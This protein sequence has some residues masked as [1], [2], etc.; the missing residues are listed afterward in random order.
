MSIP[1]SY[2]DLRLIWWLLLGLLLIGFAVTDGFDF[3]TAILLPFVARNDVERRV[4]IGT[5]DRPAE[6]SQVWFVLGGGAMVAAWPQV[7]AIA[8]SGFHA[9]LFLVLTALI[10]RPVGFKFRNKVGNPLW[11]ACWDHVLFLAGLAAALVFG[12]AT[13]NVLAGVP[14][15]LDGTMRASH[16]DGLIGLLHPFA[17]LCGMLSVAM[18]VM[19]GAAWLVA[20]TG[21]RVADRA[22][23]WGQAAAIVTLVVLA[24]GW[25]WT[26][27]LPGLRIVGGADPNGASNPLAKVVVVEIGAWLANYADHPWFAIA[28]AAG[29]IGTAIAFLCLNLRLERLA[30]VASGTGVA[31]VVATAG[32]GMFPFLLPSSLDPRSSLTVWDASASRPTLFVMLIAA[33]IFIPLILAC[34]PLVYR[35]MRGKVTAAGVAADGRGNY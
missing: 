26:A 19:H 27:A 17:L 25:V 12:I 30:P 20:K 35:M 5:V 9:A 14:F 15:R 11:R 7:Y 31:G 6:G 28:P 10:L 34:T 32:V 29:F 21:D 16:A 33:A 3:G 2:E 8:F 18:L 24:V 1:L 13:G 4:V 22:R 23:I